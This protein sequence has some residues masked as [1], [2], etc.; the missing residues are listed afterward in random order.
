[1]NIN[2]FLP[3]TNEKPLDA[4]VNDGGLI[5]IFRTLA[6]IGDSLSS[7]EFESYSEQYGK[8]YHDFYDYSWGQY[9]ARE[10]GITVYNFSRGGM[11]AKEYMESFSKY[12]GFWKEDK[13]CQGYIIALGVNDLLA[14]NMEPGKA[15]DADD[16]T[17]TTFAA[18]YGSII[19]NIKQIQP[20]A[21]IF[22]MTMPRE[23]DE[24]QNNI[25][26]LHAD[27][28]YDFAEKFDGVYVIDLFRYACVYDEEFKKTFY[29][30]GHMNAAG[31]ILTAKMVMSY[32]DYIIRNNMDDFIQVPFIDKPYYNENYKR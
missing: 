6:V 28:L 31:Y 12:N 4:F 21:R 11:T 13:L 26:K 18:Y 20:N 16:R 5:K 14:Q 7:G 25:K 19:R 8:A 24:A 22:L 10:A 17:C 23:E 32:I 29:M 30:G 2:D 9:I 1:M 27:I 15:D 3:R